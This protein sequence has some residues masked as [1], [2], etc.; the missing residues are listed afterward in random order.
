[1]KLIR[2]GG[3]VLALGLT[4]AFSACTGDD[5][6]VVSGVTDADGGGGDAAATTDDA[7]ADDATTGGPVAAVCGNGVGEPGELCDPGPASDKPCPKTIADCDDKNDCTTD[8]LV[9]GG[10]CQAKCVHAAV[11]EGSGCSAGTGTC[12]GGVCCTGCISGGACFAGSSDAQKC[13]KNGANC[14]DCSANSASATCDSGQCSGCDATSC[15]NEGRTCGTSSCGFNC[16]GCAD[17]CATGT[18]THTACSASTKNCQP[19][20]AP[21]SC[22]PYT[23]C[24]NATTCASTCANDTFCT[25]ANYCNPSSLCAP[26]AL[27]GV[28][29]TSGSECLSGSCVNGVCCT[30]PSC[31]T[32]MACNVAGK[33]GDCAPLTTGSDDPRCPHDAVSSCQHSGQCD[34]AGNCA[35][36]GASTVCAPATC[37][38]DQ[39]AKLA[40]ATCPGGGVACPSQIS[41][42]CGLYKC[43]PATALC[44]TGC[45]TCNN[46]ITTCGTFGLLHPEYCASGTGCSKN[47]NV[48]GDACTSVTCH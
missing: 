4:I 8:T 6:I 23:S 31:G 16:G 19:N 21:V 2:T 28:T 5:P 37:S 34:G 25:A 26:R 32:C 3:P 7:A 22:E 15:T 41:T 10:G 12:L 38:G 13:G 11:N 14:F 40:A 33:A 46:A 17:T 1:M 27:K 35:F 36:F 20:G 42:G 30:S 39:L 24:A 43:N 29:C 47:C 9:D 48:A 44:Y 18:L 45:G